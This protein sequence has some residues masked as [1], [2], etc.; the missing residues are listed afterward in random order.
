[1]LNSH[2]RIAVPFESH[3]YTTFYEWRQWYGDLNRP[4][5]QARLIDDI[6]KTDVLSDWDTVPDRRATLAAIEKGDFHG[7]VDALLRTYAGHH[8]KQRWGEKTPDH[9]KCWKAVLAGFPSMQVVHIIRDGRDVALSWRNA[10]FGPKHIHLLADRW[11]KY[12]NTMDELRDNLPA[13]AYCEVRYEDLIA[14]AEP[15]LRRVCEFLGEDYAPSMLTFHLNE[16]GYPTDK[17]NNA[18]L[19]KPVIKENREKWRTLL[20]SREKRLFEAVAGEELT[21]RGYART[22]P[23]AATSRLEAFACKWIEHP[24]RR[25]WAMC[26]NTKGHRDSAIKLIIYLRLQARRLLGGSA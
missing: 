18:N 16:S 25:L 21:R 19:H 1:M 23:D 10:R 5:A 13:D 15:V 11:V 3:F 6:L 14:D 2:P 26:R 22:V 20:S 7:V 4:D 9:A 8:G 24:P 12:L 17:T